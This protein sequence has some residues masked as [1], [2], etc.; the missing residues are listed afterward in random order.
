MTPK[1]IKQLR[2]DTSLTQQAFAY[3]AGIKSR[4]A[5]CEWESGKS[6]PHPLLMPALKHIRERVN[7]ENEDG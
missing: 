3:L 5:V 4:S 7:R 1:E 6:K 2:K